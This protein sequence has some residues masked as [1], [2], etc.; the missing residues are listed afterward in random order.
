MKR[1]FFAAAVLL[2]VFGMAVVAAGKRHGGKTQG[3]FDYYMLALSWAP[4]YCAG[5]PTD[6][7]AECRT[8]EHTGFLLHGLWPQANAGSTPVNC[9]GVSPVSSDL[10]REMSN[11][12]PSRGLVQHEWQT[13]GSCSGL[14]ATDYF[15]AVKQSLSAVK[16]PDAY[17]NL[18]Q[19]RNLSVREIEQA[20]AGANGAP[21][22]AFRI[23]CH[24]GELVNLEACLT[25]DMAF[26]A[27]TASARE[28]PASQ[29]LM[30]A[31]R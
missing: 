9:G 27:C 29:V 31:V 19:D 17:R 10:V 4:N 1:A 15:S 30:R 28:C 2:C 23:S 22:G 8:G 11:Y 18:N 6:K 24:D 12:Y 7:S 25:K 21:A 13:H 16:V 3:G 14:S 26:Q 20:F 5:H